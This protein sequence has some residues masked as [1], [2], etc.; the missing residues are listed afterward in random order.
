MPAHLF[1]RKRKKVYH[2]IINGIPHDRNA[3]A[4]IWAYA[5]YYNAKHRSGRQHRGP[6]TWATQRVLKALLYKRHN[7]KNGALLP[8]L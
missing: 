4:R 6:M 3:K 1:G 5:K 8:G 7:S 2:E